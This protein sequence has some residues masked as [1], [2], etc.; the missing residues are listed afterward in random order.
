MQVLVFFLAFVISLCTAQQWN[1]LPG[2]AVEI[3]AKGKE[4]WVINQSQRIYRWKGSNW[5]L[6]PGAAVRV[7]ASPDG[8]TWVV[9][10][11][12]NIY[13]WNVLKNNW[14]QIQG[15]LTQIDAISKDRGNCSNRKQEKIVNRK[16][17][18]NV[19]IGV[20]RANNIYLWENNAWKQLPGAAVW[21]GIGDGDERWV[22]NAAQQIYRWNHSTNNWDLMPGA[23][24][25]IDVQNPCRVIVTNSKNQIFIW[26]NNAWKLLTGAGTRSTINEDHYYTVNSAQKIYIGQ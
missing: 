12:D 7:G 17:P 21:A 23:A 15:A 24:V 13:R 11:A 2:A 6:K 5:E 16:F 26:K 18:F 10:S 14:D 22:V 19:A 1:Q 20:N 25:N 3:S 8:W 4:L 9:N